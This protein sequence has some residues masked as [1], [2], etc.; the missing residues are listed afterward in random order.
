MIIRAAVLGRPIEPL[1][2]KGE[3][4]LEVGDLVRVPLGNTRALACVISKEKGD[5]KGLK[6]TEEVLVTKLFPPKVLGLA[7]H[8]A[9]EYLGFLGEALGLILPK[10]ITRPPKRE[11]KKREE[12][13]VHR[14]LRMRADEKEILDA[15]R[16]STKPML[17]HS[18]ADYTALLVELI[19]DFTA[20]GKEVLLIFPDEPSLARSYERLSTYLPLALYHS[21]M[22]QGERRRVWHG[23][24]QGLIPVVVGLRSTVLLPFTNLGLIVVADEDS[25]SLR[26]RSHHLHYNARDLALFRGENEDAKVMLLSLA[27]SLE[28]S[29][30]ARSGKLSWIE[31]R[32]A[33]K[34]KALIVDMKKEKE[35]TVLSQPLLDEVETARN[36]GMQALLLLNRLGIASRLL[37]L[38]CGHVPTCS[39]CDIPL[40]FVSRGGT[41]ACPVCRKEV[42]AQEQCPRCGGARW[43]SIAPG[44]AALDKQLKRYFPRERLVKITAEHRPIIEDAKKADIIYGT[45]AA[46]EYQPPRVQVAAFLSW[47]AERSRPDFRSAERAF[48]DVAYLRR[49]LASTQ[50]S[51]LVVQTYRPQNLLLRWALK[52]DYEAFF[53]SETRRRKEL[54]YPPYRRLMIFEQSKGMKAWDAEKLTK[55]LQH[56]GAEVLGPYSGRRSKTCILVKLRRDLRPGDLIDAATLYKSGWRVDVDPVEI[57]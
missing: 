41:M 56:E 4:L 20:E 44:L 30:K 6:E 8:I 18:S 57:L 45:S 5:E 46:L 11:I 16:K 28:T 32:V 19:R 50:D 24:R 27:P 2:Y 39:S 51:R 55:A 42:P 22:G 1:R 7:R 35:E 53:K 38:D 48:R 12:H 31:R 21:E 17:I 43:Q 26:V 10:D 52:A 49:I 47:D 13:K 33:Q 9:N 34:G 29:H 36:Q 54:G 37:C 3:P 25:D 40:K 23:V 15:L 14:E